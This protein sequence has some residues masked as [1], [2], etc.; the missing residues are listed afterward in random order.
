M[1]WHQE[2]MKDVVACDMPRGVGERAFDPRISEWGNLAAVVCSYHHLKFIG[3]WGERGEV[4]HLGTRRRR[5]SVS[6][7][8]R[9]RR[10]LNLVCVRAGRRCAWGVVGHDRFSS[11]GEW[12]VCVA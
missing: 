9:K 1:P 10:R 11:A 7:G 8:E 2:L 6:S 4:K 5:Y 3:W 12:H